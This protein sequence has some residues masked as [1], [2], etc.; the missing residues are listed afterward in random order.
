MTKF[1]YLYSGGSMA[2]TPEEQEAAMQAWVA[3]FGTL[4]GALIDGG[5][6]FASAAT[7]AADGSVSDGGASAITGYSLINADSLDDAVTT[8]KDCPVLAT[9]GSVQVYQALEM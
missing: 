4:G 8:A 7:I 9:G 6:P 2:E 3:W 1:V 5:N